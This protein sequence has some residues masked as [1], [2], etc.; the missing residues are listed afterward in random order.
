MKQKQEIP[1]KITLG[2][3]QYGAWKCTMLPQVPDPGS[4]DAEQQPDEIWVFARSLKEIVNEIP[5]VESAVLLGR[6]VCIADGET[7]GVLA[8]GPEIAQAIAD[9]NPDQMVTVVCPY[10]GSTYPLSAFEHPPEAP[11]NLVKCPNEMCHML[12]N[13]ARL[14]VPQP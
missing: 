13:P 12:I 5:G 8:P 2:V 11:G 10:C 1:Q 6:A 7:P 14:K 3:G 4:Q 9:S